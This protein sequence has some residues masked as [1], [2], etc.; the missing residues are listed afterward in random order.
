MTTDIENK[1][2]RLSVYVPIE[3][4]RSYFEFPRAMHG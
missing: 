4:L 3:L 2:E 1:L